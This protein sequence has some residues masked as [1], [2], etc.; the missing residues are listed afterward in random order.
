M[1][2]ASDFSRADEIDAARRRTFDTLDLATRERTMVDPQQEHEYGDESNLI[3]PGSS[4]QRVMV[5]PM[6]FPTM[7]KATRREQKFAAAVTAPVRLDPA[8][9]ARQII[10]EARTTA[11]MMLAQA[12]DAIAAERTQAVQQGYDEG[13]A[14]G[15]AEADAET[16]GLVQTCEKIG[17]HVME[18]R[19]RVLDENEA[20]LVELAMAVAR[21]IVNAAID[22]DETLVIEACR[23]A[24]RK[25][26]QRGSMTVLA[27]P[28][29]LALLRDAGPELAAELGGVDHLDFVEERRLDRGSV[30]VRTPAGEID[31]TIEGKASKIE[32]ALREGIEQRRAERRA[33]AA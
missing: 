18:E 31:A 21:R 7:D 20:D 33:N 4:S 23:G 11:R 1:A 32:Q 14:K 22:V 3:V 27:H 6:L 25:A 5:E 28:G 24:M 16:A 17:I 2:F 26:F 29:D 19:A 30:I 15:A 9:E 12:R 10:A 13:F 8:E